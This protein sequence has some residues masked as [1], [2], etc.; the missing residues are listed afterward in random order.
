MRIKHRE[1]VSQPVMLGLAWHTFCVKQTQ[2][3]KPQQSSRPR[4]FALDN[5]CRTAMSKLIKQVEQDRVLLDLRRYPVQKYLIL[6][7]IAVMHYKFF[8][9]CK[10]ALQIF[11][12]MRR[13]FVM[14]LYEYDTCFANHRRQQAL[15]CQQVIQSTKA[16]KAGVEK[17]EK[18]KSGVEKKE[19]QVKVVLE[20]VVFI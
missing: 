3:H 11:F 20:K 9:Q 19:K 1:T 7:V 13:K 17:V 16:G 4:H 10:S 18:E 5:S 14:H 8:S 2:H 15:L 12:L 6:V